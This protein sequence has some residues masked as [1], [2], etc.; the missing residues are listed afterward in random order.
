MT[1][2]KFNPTEIEVCAYAQRVVRPGR[3]INQNRD[4]VA[5][6]TLVE[7][8]GEYFTSQMWLKVPAI[9]LSLLLSVSSGKFLR[10]KTGWLMLVLLNS[11]IKTSTCWYGAVAKRSSSENNKYSKTSVCNLLPVHYTANILR[12]S[13]AACLNRVVCWKL[14]LS[15]QNF[16][17]IK[18]TCSFATWWFFITEPLWSNLKHT[19]NTIFADVPSPWSGGIIRR[20]KKK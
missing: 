15:R 10:V 7:G 11:N 12:S 8:R 2:K 16:V 13:L 1:R 5:I 3:S 9:C 17:E 14:L 20:V 18:L 6:S 19:K 4:G